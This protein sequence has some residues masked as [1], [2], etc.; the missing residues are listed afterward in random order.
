MEAI[1]QLFWSSRPVSWIN[2]AFPFGATYLFINNR[3][4]LTFIVG[5]LFFLIPYNLLM[6]GINDVF[7][8]ESD[9]RNPRKGGIEGALLNK[10]WHKLTLWSSTLLCVPFLVYL[11]AISDMNSA[12]W[13]TLFIFTVV[14]YSAPKLR[15]KERGF[16]DSLTSASHFVGPMIYALSLS[17]VDL[18]ERPVLSSILAFT[19]W[20]IAS[21]AFGAVQ[22]VKA[23]READISSIATMIGAKATVWFAFIAYAAAG[24]L[25]MNTI[26]PGPL[27]AIAAIPYLLILTPYL[28]ITDEDC[29]RANKGWR[30][31]IWLNFFAG[32]VVSLILIWSSIN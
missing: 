23:D 32:A 8:Y 21:H 11:Y 28:N 18:A 13:L 26:W 29:E 20:G 7:D 22:D 27:A 30:R 12:L 19:L 14:A 5:T 16:L 2:T 17:G 4:D 1:K 3:V 9:L 10:K 25:V 15:F 6:Y 24:V 31:F